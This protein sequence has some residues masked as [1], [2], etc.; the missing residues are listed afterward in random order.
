MRTR[1]YLLIVAVIAILVGG[2]TYFVV[3]NADARE[4]SPVSKAPIS[5]IGEWHQIKSEPN[6]ILMNAKISAGSIQINLK[7]RDNVSNIYWLG[8]FDTDVAPVESVEIISE[9]DPDAMEKSIFGSRDK[10]KLFNYANG[11]ISYKFTMMGAT[12]TIHLVKQ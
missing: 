7:T 5:L 2:S 4:N 3:S 1:T 10:N 11:E 8:T 9:G 6:G 12:T